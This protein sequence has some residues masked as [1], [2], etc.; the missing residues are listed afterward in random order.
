MFFFSC[1]QAS[2]LEGE[3]DLTKCFKVCE[4]QVQRNYGFQIHVREALK[5][6]N[7]QLWVRALRKFTSCLCTTDPK[8]YPHTFS[9]DSWNTEELDPGADEERA[10]RPPPQRDQVKP[11]FYIALFDSSV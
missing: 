5:L 10:S 6:S 7:H 1:S 3:I 4:Y 9:H 8:R 2:D 11:W